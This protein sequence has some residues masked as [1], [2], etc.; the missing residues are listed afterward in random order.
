MNLN[1]EYYDKEKKKILSRKEKKKYNKEY[2]IN[3]RKQLQN[4]EKC[5]IYVKEYKS[6]EE[7]KITI[8]EGKFLIEM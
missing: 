8:E 5:R 4:I 3:V 7:L 6:D 2:Y 1:Q